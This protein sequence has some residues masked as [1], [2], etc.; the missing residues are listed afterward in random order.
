MYVC[1]YV[2]VYMY[3]YRTYVTLETHPSFFPSLGLSLAELHWTL[4]GERDGAGLALAFTFALLS[5]L[6]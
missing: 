4:R 3:V 2:C 1:M 5:Y 6:L